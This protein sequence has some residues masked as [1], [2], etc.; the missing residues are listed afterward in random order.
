M[1]KYLEIAFCFLE[2]KKKNVETDVRK[3]FFSFKHNRHISTS[4][5]VIKKPNGSL[6]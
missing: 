4:G 3:Y 2:E 1:Q 6:H 5:E